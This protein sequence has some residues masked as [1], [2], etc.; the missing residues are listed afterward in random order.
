MRPHDY[1]LKQT[2]VGVDINQK[3]KGIP[4]PHS[5]HTLRKPTE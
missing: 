5:R 1:L 2:T 3:E 4:A